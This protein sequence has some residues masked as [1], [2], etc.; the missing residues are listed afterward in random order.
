MKKLLIIN[1]APELEDMLIDCLLMDTAVSGYTSFM[2][3]GHGRHSGM[4]IS[5]QVAGHRKRIQFELVI[6]QDE[7]KGLLERLRSV[8]KGI[9]FRIMP[10]DDVGYLT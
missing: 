5:E 9:Y 1:I 8:G 2:V 4:S 10:I 3:R 6:E 7:I